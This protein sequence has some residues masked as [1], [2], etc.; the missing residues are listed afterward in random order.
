MVSLFFERGQM[1]EETL[2]KYMFPFFCQI[3]CIYFIKEVISFL[4][5][6]RFIYCKAN[7]VG[8]NYE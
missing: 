4:T 3:T 8:L 2:E 6:T 1:I 7:Y 5:H